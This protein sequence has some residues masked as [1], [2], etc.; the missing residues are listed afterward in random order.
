[1]YKVLIEGQEFNVTEQD[2]QKLDVVFD[3]NNDS[4]Q[5][6]S[7]GNSYNIELISKSD[8]NKV[9][10][11]QVND[12]NIVTKIMDVLDQQVDS[13]GLSTIDAHKSNDIFAPMPG[14]ILDILCEEGEE[15]EEG[16][17]LLIL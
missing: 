4:Y 9:Q 15:V 6:L 13:M 2:L 11:L 12:L 8:Q 14:L 17:S 16:K 10:S 5:V 3:K 7:D 1:M